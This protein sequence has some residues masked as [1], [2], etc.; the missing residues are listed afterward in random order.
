[1]GYMIP[2]SW[3]ALKVAILFD[4]SSWGVISYFA[5]K[6]KF[7]WKING[8]L[9]FVI[10]I[11]LIIIWAIFSTPFLLKGE[12]SKNNIIKNILNKE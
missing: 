10:L 9:F 11:I 8:A 12:L 2:L 5:F 7:Y 6:I 4:C 1:L 3:S